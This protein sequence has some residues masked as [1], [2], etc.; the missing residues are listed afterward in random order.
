M[1][2]QGQSLSTIDKERQ[3]AAM[4]EMN[5]RIARG[6]CPN[7]VYRHFD[8]NAGCGWNHEFGV[9][10]TPLVFVHL[11]D[12]L[13]NRWRATFY[14]RDEQRAQQLWQRLRGVPHVTILHADNREVLAAAKAIGSYDLGSLLVDPNGWL[15]RNQEGQGCPIEEMVRF[16]QLYP[17]IDLIANMNVRTYV[18]MRGAAKNHRNHPHYNGLHGLQ[19][20]PG[21]FSKRHGLISALSS[22][23]QSQ[24]VR[25]ILR[26]IKT[27]DYRA[28]GWHHLDSPVAAEIYR[29]AE[30]EKE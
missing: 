14:E 26:N 28:E 25:L 10:G 24:F 17:R 9:P 21:L 5:M 8:L 16:F 15:Y 29:Y 20:M 12:K 11:A 22:N 13:L 2:A 30:G 3:F 27:N 7:A 1:S 23:G 6:A 4:L 19:E 18:R